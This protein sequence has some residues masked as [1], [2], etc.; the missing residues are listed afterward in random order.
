MTSEQFGRRA[1]GAG[2]PVAHQIPFYIGISWGIVLSTYMPEP[3]K[4]PH[5]GC[6]LPCCSGLKQG[7][8]SCPNHRYSQTALS[9]GRW[10][11]HTSFSTVP[12]LTTQHFDM[13]HLIFIFTSQTVNSS[14]SETVTNLFIC[15][16]QGLPPSGKVTVSSSGSSKHPNSLGFSDTTRIWAS[17]LSGTNMPLTRRPPRHQQKSCIF[18]C[19]SLSWMA[20]GRHV[21]WYTQDP[22]TL[23]HNGG[24]YKSERAFLTSQCLHHVSEQI[25]KFVSL[26]FQC[27]QLPHCTCWTYA[28]SITTAV[29]KCSCIHVMKSHLGGSMCA[30][31]L[32][33]NKV[34]SFEAL[35]LQK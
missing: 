35:L 32:H 17:C 2:W 8:W 25:L 29:P 4:N 27:L 26:C 24:C 30:A 11:G 10:T 9:R 15:S 23:H 12:P 31:P 22:S 34:S 20:A 6:H 19:S 18:W 13:H 33:A 7:C 1:G 16:C 5:W 14:H 28:S 21:F 3:L